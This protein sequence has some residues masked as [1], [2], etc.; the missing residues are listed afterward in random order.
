MFLYRIPWI[1]FYIQSVLIS[2]GSLVHVTMGTSV[3][4]TARVLL[5]LLHLH[6]SVTD[7]KAF[8][9]VSQIEEIVSIIHCIGSYFPT[10]KHVT[11]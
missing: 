1:F 7:S 4:S 8:F 3:S 6:N 11:T 9:N 2:N 10:L 5:H